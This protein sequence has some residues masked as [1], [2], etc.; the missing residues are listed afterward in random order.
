[1]GNHLISL[2]YQPEEKRMKRFLICIFYILLLTGCTDIHTRL[3]PMIL[4]VD[5]AESV[6]FAAQT[7]L[8]A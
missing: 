6:Q 2:L 5:T 3:L 8:E 7:S 1:M 4:A